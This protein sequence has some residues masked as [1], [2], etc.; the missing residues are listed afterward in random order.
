M[1][2]RCTR[3]GL[4]AKGVITELPRGWSWRL[5]S[6]GTKAVPERY[7]ARCEACVEREHKPPK[8]DA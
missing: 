4:R 1:T 5:V 6:S 2:W 8:A 7:E 3:C